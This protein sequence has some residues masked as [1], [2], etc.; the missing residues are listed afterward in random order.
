MKEPRKGARVTRGGLNA[1]DLSSAE[2]T[3][4]YGNVPCTIEANQQL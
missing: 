4:T 2:G 3:G 1:G